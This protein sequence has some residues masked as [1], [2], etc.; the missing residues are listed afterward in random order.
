MC[1]CVCWGGEASSGNRRLCFIYHEQKKQLDKLI[2]L[3][4]KLNESSELSKRDRAEMKKEI[5][6]IEQDCWWDLNRDGKIILRELRVVKTMRTRP[7]VWTG[8]SNY[9]RLLTRAAVRKPSE[10]VVEQL[11]SVINIQN[12]EN[13]AWS[14]LLTEVQFRAF[15]PYAHEWGDLI[16]ALYR[17]LHE[18][19]HMRSLVQHPDR[20]RRRSAYLQGSAST[21]RLKSRKS[22]FQGFVGK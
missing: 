16:K 11:I 20:R 21:T 7:T 8:N 13:L 4:K 1:V 19:E 6:T 9:M 10:T 5:K 2:R 17:K 3:H 18:D 15:G 14:C 12:R 22:K